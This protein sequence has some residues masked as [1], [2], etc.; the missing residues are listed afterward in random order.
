MSPVTAPRIG[1][2]TRWDDERGYGFI[3]PQAGD[4]NGDVFVHVSAFV[5]RQRPQVGQVLSYHLEVA[6]DGRSRAIR[7]L[8]PGESRVPRRKPANHTQ[9]GWLWKLAPFLLLVII[10]GFAW[11]HFSKLRAT[12]ALVIDSSS[13]SFPA[14]PGSPSNTTTPLNAYQCDGRTHCSQMRSCDEAKYFLR[15]CPGTKMDG[16]GDGIPCEQQWCRW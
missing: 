1:T 9:S 5:G 16:D 12:R 4:G 2:L 7:V 15:H 3:T 6:P 13:L 10:A 14:R 11:N 8:R